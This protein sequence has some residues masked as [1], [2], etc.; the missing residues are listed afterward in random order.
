MNSSSVARRVLGLSVL[1]ACSLSCFEQ[2]VREILYLKFLPGDAVVVGVTVKLAAE[3]V[4]KENRAARERI[5]SVRRDLLESRDDWSRRIESVEPALERTTWDREAGSLR[6]VSR[7]IAL[8]HPEDLTR[9]FSDTLIRAQITI[10]D[11]ETELTLTPG[12]G[13]R[14]SRSQRSEFEARRT[15]WLESYAR[16]LR[17]T[18]KL[19]TY[20]EANG[21]RAAVC[22]KEV[23]REEMETEEKDEREAPTPQEQEM[24]DAVRK[25]IEESLELFSLPGESPYSLEE[26]SRLVYDPFPAP[27]TVQVPGAILQVE[28][29]AEGGEQVVKVRELGLWEALDALGDRWVD[30]NLLVLKYR[31]QIDKKPLDLPALVRLKRSAG[32]PPSSAE[33]QRALETN[34]APA[35]VYRL[36]WSTRNLKELD[37]SEE[38]EELWQIPASQQD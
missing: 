32:T 15:A 11:G 19:Y 2:P 18:E 27:L 14:A 4:F 8:E 33:I 29:F 35:P 20:L 37:P 12:S 5:E 6:S 22:L 36:K 25:S 23:F 38:V 16:T 7:R 31:L 3:D 10:L 30:P 24:T 26:L 1:A 9:F 21:T 28:G 17:A 13:S 34:L